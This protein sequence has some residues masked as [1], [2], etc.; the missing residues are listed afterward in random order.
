MKRI[1]C[2]I[3]YYG[4]ARYLPPS[5]SKYGGKPSKKIRYLVCKNIFKYCGKNVNIE[6]LAFFAKGTNIRIG[7]NS[8]LGL[9]SRV[10]DNTIL[11]KNVMM[12]LIAI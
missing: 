7:D 5:Y 2:L 1:L 12:G 3:L 10:H 4:F 8:G 11:G 6:R 9:N